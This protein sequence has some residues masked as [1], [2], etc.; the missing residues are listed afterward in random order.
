MSVENR[1]RPSLILLVEIHPDRNPAT[2]TR[3][4]LDGIKN[5]LVK[6][7]GSAPTKRTIAASLGKMPTTLARR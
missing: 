4:V 2:F 7:Q 6:N 5:Q 3:I 1:Y